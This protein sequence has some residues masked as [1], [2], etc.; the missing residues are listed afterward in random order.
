MASGGSVGV[1]LRV[2]SMSAKDCSKVRSTVSRSTCFSGTFA[3]SSSSWL[4]CFVTLAALNAA[5]SAFARSFIASA[6]SNMSRSAV[7]VKMLAL[8]M[9]GMMAMQMCKKSWMQTSPCV[10][11]SVR[12]KRVWI[13]SRERQIWSATN[14]ISLILHNFMWPVQSN[15]DRRAQNT[16]CLRSDRRSFATTAFS[17][18]S[19]RKFSKAS[20]SSSK[21]RK[22]FSSSGNICK[23]ID[24]SCGLMRSGN[25][26][27][28][29]RQYLL[30]RATKVC[31]FSP[32][33]AP[34]APSSPCSSINRIHPLVT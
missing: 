3:P 32:P 9:C 21:P 4:S 29:S 24:P 15:P 25:D 27:T 33:S 20:V 5:N 13:W 28:E 1:G 14:N 12:H 7:S 10:L 11:G 30:W 26:A 8:L 2:S 23:T 22:P 31:A 34:K 16:R 6:F 18:A 19:M 17:K